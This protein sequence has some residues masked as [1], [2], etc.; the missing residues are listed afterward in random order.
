MDAR[1]LNWKVETPSKD[2]HEKNDLS[3]IFNDHYE[4]LLNYGAQFN[5]D[6]QSVQDCIH[7]LFVDIWRT[8][9]SLEELNSPKAY[10]L[11]ALKNKIYKK[12]KR[13]NKTIGID[14][15][16]DQHL[17]PIQVS[18][19]QSTIISETIEHNREALNKSIES[20]T[21]RQRELI[22]HIFYN[23]LTYEEASEVLNI[24][25]KTA[26]NLVL[27]SI[28][29]LRKHLDISKLE[30]VMVFLLLRTIQ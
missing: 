5:L 21:P 27:R 1:Q 23:G 28:N 14:E 15:Y 4:I 24:S 19:E 9:K 12:L 20:L 29:K 2:P 18:I 13:E 26:Y 30:V 11:R 16:S 7:D 10:L 17:F 22:Y 6:K 8:A 3:S 25:K